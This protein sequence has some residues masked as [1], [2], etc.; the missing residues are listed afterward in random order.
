M[1]KI[2]ALILSLIMLL[3]VSCSERGTQPEASASIDIN[4]Q[5]SQASSKANSATEDSQESQESAPSEEEHSSKVSEESSSEASTVEEHSSEVSTPPLQQSQAATTQSEEAQTPPPES[6]QAQSTEA[7]TPLNELDSNSSQA[8]SQEQE[9]V[10]SEAPEED[11]PESEETSQQKDTTPV[12]KPDEVR[13]V[14]VSYLDFYSLL[15]GKSEAQFK[16]NIDTAFK[17]IKDSG[18]NTAIVQ[19]RPFAD[20]LYP[21]EYFPWSHIINGEAEGV[22]PGFDPLQIMVDAAKDYGLRIEAWINPYRVRASSSLPSVSSDSPATTLKNTDAVIKYG[23][24]TYFNPASETARD[25]ITD[26]VI[27]IVQNYDIDAI[28]FDDYFYPTTD[29]EFDKASYNA[30][31]NSGGTLALADWRRENV[32]KLVSQVYS[33]INNVSSEVEFGISPQANFENNYDKQYIDVAKWLSNSGYIDY[34]LPQVYFGFENETYPFE[35]TVQ[36][37]NDLIK[38]NGID[39]YIGLSPYKIGTEDTW[40]GSGANEWMTDDEILARM[41]E[42]A[43]SLENYDGFAMY[44]YDSLY[45]PSGAVKSQI[46]EELSAVEDIM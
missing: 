32:N 11:A 8:S 35:E 38:V 46:N 44:R 4:T 26:G 29:T 16:S 39:L 41:I 34:I 6:S 20:A 18:F 9:P 17:N 19:V 21:S 31:K 24:G 1:K 14:W 3:S 5:S 36:R 30:Y 43:R 28:H 15:R 45:N 40:A 33:A 10:S 22:N 12:V 42:E 27:E 2:S 7:D 25:L 13:A 37:W 23:D